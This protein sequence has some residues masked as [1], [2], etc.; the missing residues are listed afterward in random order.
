MSKPARGLG[1][2][3]AVTAVKRTTPSWASADAGAEG[4][5]P[6][7]TSIVS[8][9]RAAG[10]GLG[11]AEA[12]IVSVRPDEV[13]EHPK[14]PRDS[15][16][17]LDELTDSLR[18]FGLIQAI[19][20]VPSNAFLERYP[21]YSTVVGA[22]PWVVVAGHRRRAAAELAPLHQI[23]AIVRPDLADNAAAA[24]AFIVE[25]I[26][27]AGLKPL[28]EARTYA[29]LADLG[30]SQRE[31]ASRCS[32]SQSHVSKR[33]SLLQLPQDAQDALTSGVLTIGE[34]LALAA[35]PSEDQGFLWH[36]ISTQDKP[37][38]TARAELAQQ[39]EDDQRVS[40]A[41]SQARRE[42]LPVIDPAA[43][44]G[45]GAGRHRLYDAAGVEEARSA[46]HLVGAATGQGLIYYTR[47]E[48]IPPESPQQAPTLPAASSR[49]RNSC[50]ALVG[51][52][53][54][55]AEALEDLTRAALRG[56]V[57][58]PAAAVLAAEWLPELG[59]GTAAEGERAGDP[60]E[61]WVA[62][63]RE[64][65]PPTQVWA[66]W[67]LAIAQVELDL[68]AGSELPPPVRQR[69]LARLEAAGHV[70]VIDVDAARPATAEL[71]R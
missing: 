48:V 50:R 55:E 29:L 3:A 37:V 42:G 63:V 15:L 27:R 41:R 36:V 14:N 56:S 49:R 16:G 11:L 1:T 8:A 54:A 52:P 25:N 18:T 34:A 70:E 69:H 53:P 5:T 23:D 59:G 20:V 61:A 65:D 33:L 28:E 38:A 40:E 17:D 10:P 22:R 57:A 9:L 62:A 46:G 7:S 64:A 24:T 26:H 60:I 51:S 12:R 47:A 66:A 19:V 35:A 45:K 67:A 31:I 6:A 4:S 2:G 39:R 58:S 30:L 44:F 13:A 43:E 21:E 32:V 71:S 68:E